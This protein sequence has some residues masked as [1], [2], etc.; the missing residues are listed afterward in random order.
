MAEK[1]TK[2]TVGSKSKR[3]LSLDKD[4]KNLAEI[5]R[6][7]LFQEDKEKIVVPKPIDEFSREVT[8][9]HGR[10]SLTQDGRDL[11]LA[12]STNGTNYD[13]NELLYQITKGD[14]AIKC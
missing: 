3:A 2:W 7:T 10:V 11:L 4:G 6:N 14:Y 1:Y 9:S 8:F 5:V 13:F 12:I